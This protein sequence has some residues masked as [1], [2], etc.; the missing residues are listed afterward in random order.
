MLFRKEEAILPSIAASLALNDVF[1]QRLNQVNAS[2]AAT[3]QLMARLQ[4]QMQNPMV[5]RISAFDVISN[6][7]M[8]KQQ[9]AALGTGSL[10]RININTTEILQQLAV[11]R[12][13]LG[14]EESLIKIKINTADISSQIAIIKRQIESELSSVVAQIRIEL[15]RSLEAMFTN[16]QRLVSQL[17]RSTRQLR[18]RSADAGELQRALERIARLERQIADLQSRVN[19]QINNATKNTSNWLSSLKNVVAAYLSIAA[20]KK[21]L[22]TS[23]DV[24]L[25]NARLAMVNDGLRT[26][27][28]LQRQVM[29]AAND[30]RAN[31]QATADMVTKLAM[32]TQGIFKTD[33]DII[34]FTK[35]FNKAL[36]I[37]GA[38]AQETTASILQMG[39]A[40]GS[41]VLQGDELRSLSENAPAVM[42]LLA[43]GLG[44]A[45]GELKAMGA[46]G[47]L[48][49]AMIVKAFEKQSGKIDKM[50]SQMPMTFGSAMTIMKNK[51]AEWIGT[52]N[53]AE[54]PLSRITKMLQ[55]LTAWLS[56]SD[57]EQ[58]LSGLSEGITTTVDIVVSLGDAAAQVYSYIT[59]NWTTIEPI[60]WG[61]AAALTA[62]KLASM[63]V[64]SASIFASLGTGIMTAAVFLQTAATGGLALAWRGLNAA[65]KANIFILVATLL[66]GLIMWLIKLWN[67]NDAFAAGFLRVWYGILNFIDQVAIKFT[68]VGYA[69]AD[70]FGWA[71]TKSLIFMEDLANGAIDR[72]NDLINTLNKLPFVELE[73][74]SHIELAAGKAA[75][76]EAAKQQRAANLAAMENSAATKAKEREAKVQKMLD[77]RATKRESEAAAENAKNAKSGKD[78]KVAGMGFS[79]GGGAAAAA[80]PKTDK[81]KKVDKVGKVEKP[82]DI[83]KEDLKIMRDVAEMKNIQNFVTLTPTI[84][85]KTGPVTNEA[86][87]DSIVKKIETKLNEDIASTAKGLYS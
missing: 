58:F 41:G 11:I 14:G 83:S 78:D 18:T 9:I 74:I 1:S 31:Y 16:L 70:A 68:S 67:T 32:S 75:E 80:A 64:G 48:T 76:E 28:E 30:T 45:R 4:S 60:V 40:L 24:A 44:V 85:V 72:I 66:A 79:A 10:I 55:D 7:D 39:Q 8:I 2:L 36:V 17:I 73:T 23:D 59:T 69:I 86:N 25:T 46:D 26:Q 61:I 71:K 51:V 13:R 56:T 27:L 53:G 15:P 38:G 47:K 22:E 5:L 87:V 12:Q 77:E 43:E 50:F 33:D 29:D 49:S 34:K 42:S 81:L 20:A 37:S 6:L 63:A 19:G 57:G 35:S 52:I 84:Q 62:W 21:L 54:G 82:I 65:M 3:I